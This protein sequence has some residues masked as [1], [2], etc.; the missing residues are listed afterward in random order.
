MD[1][2]TEIIAFI[3]KCQKDWN[4]PGI[5]V[6]VVKDGEVF[7]SEGIGYRDVD[8]KLEINPDTIMPIASSTKTFATT[9]ISMLVDE[10]LI[11]WDAKVRDY[12]PEFSLMDEYASNHTTPRDL[13]CHRTGL[14]RHDLM[15]YK[16][17]LPIAE[18]VRRIRYLEPNMEFRSAMQYQ[19]QMFMTLGYLIEK[20]TGMV[21]TE[22]VYEKIF[23]PLGMDRSNFT[24][25][26]SLKD[27]NY[28]KGYMKDEE[29]VKNLP[30]ANCDGAGTAGAINSTLNDMIKYLKFH[31]NRG[32]VGNIQLV[33]EENLKEIHTP[34]M[35]VR[36]FMPWEFKEIDFASYGLGWF[37]ES[38]RGHRLN[39]H[40]GTIT[41]F[42]NNLSFMPEEGLGVIVFTNLN[43]N[44]AQEAIN[45]GIYDIM[46]DLERIDWSSRYL[47][48][49]KK[50]MDAS[51]GQQSSG[52]GEKIKKEKKPMTCSLEE[53]VGIYEDEGYGVLEIKL[54]GN[55]LKACYNT[56]IWPCEHNTA[57]IFTLKLEEFET[58]VFA[59]FHLDLNGDINS[60]EAGI[61]FRPD[62]GIIFKKK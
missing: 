46:L 37:V 40:G 41:G 2:H 16:V 28:C 14:P 26:D 62:K 54:E 8:N 53:Y 48:A 20:V 10:G 56:M 25:T 23:K 55:E 60:F 30:L 32:K 29:T 12:I 22:V 47:E 19:N 34:Q 17:D 38:Y 49:F 61:T 35:V 7:F 9:V 1:K 45:Y 5:S 11:D 33:S 42:Q 21:W 31:L 6:A 15:M 3:K 58:E 59:R 44:L 52:E 57:D 24:I 36:D 51:A 39:H 18:L 43:M 4:I 27:S 50:M 13:A